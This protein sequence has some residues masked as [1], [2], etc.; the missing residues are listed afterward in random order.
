MRQVYDALAILGPTASGKSDVAIELAKS[1]DGEVI[2]CDSRQVY[3]Y[4]DIGTGKIANDFSRITNFQ[5]PISNK[6][7][8][9]RTNI[10]NRIS[11]DSPFP[12]S[13]GRCPKDREGVDNKKC[14]TL[15]DP[16]STHA[17]ISEG[18]RHHLL[19]VVHPN[20]DYNV[21]HFQKDAR[22][23]LSDIIDRKKLPILCGG[24]GLWAQALVE[25]YSIPQVAPQPQFRDELKKLSLQKLQQK[26]RDLDISTYETIDTNNPVRLI[27]ALEKILFPPPTPSK[28]IQLKSLPITW[29]VI[30]LAPPKEILHKNIEKRLDERLRNGMME[31]VQTLHDTHGVS[32][33]RLHNFGLEYRW[34]SRHLQGKI[35]FEDMR[36]RLL[37]ES[38]QYAKRQL[39]WLRRW[40]RQ[41]RKIVWVETKEEAM[42]R[43]G[44]EQGVCSG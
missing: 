16:C 15:D 6:N 9:E 40:E 31:E 29:T 19:D 2:S 38:R 32:W 24:T 14:S 39:T 3:R 22:V 13:R 36:D 44:K 1:L 21:A 20:D 5:F 26:L 4:M 12:Q 30:V 8:S 28:N 43:G 33:E 37:I 10:K 41:G 27:R 7:T 11:S 18:V 23:A 17:F 35:S 34:V 42:Q 25:N